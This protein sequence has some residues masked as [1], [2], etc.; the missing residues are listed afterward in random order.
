M[1][2]TEFNDCHSGGGTKEQWEKI[3]IEAPKDE[4]VTVFYNRF[5]HNPRRVSCTCCGPDYCIWEEECPP[6]N[7]GEDVLIIRADDIPPEER[8]G[9]VPVQGYVWK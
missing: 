8:T 9:D 1:T 2:W 5:G 7:P 6:E 4:A 3:F